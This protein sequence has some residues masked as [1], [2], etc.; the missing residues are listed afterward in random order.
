MTIAIHVL[1]NISRSKGSQAMKFGQLIEHNMRNVFFKSYT[2]CH[3]DT[4]PRPFSK[5]IKIEHI[6][7]YAATLLETIVSYKPL[8]SLSQE[9]RKTLPL[10]L[11]DTLAI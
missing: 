8:P 2:K 9:N 5:K 7:G 4:I 6:S 10:T 1:S 11:L 3:G